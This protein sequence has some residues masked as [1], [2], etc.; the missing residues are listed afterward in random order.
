VTVAGRIQYV[1]LGN[2]IKRLYV[3]R[4]DV[5]LSMESLTTP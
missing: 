4:P 3:L 1:V 5:D 2:K